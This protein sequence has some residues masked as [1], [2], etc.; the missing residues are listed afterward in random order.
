MKDENAFYITNEDN[1]KFVNKTKETAFWFIHR[2]K[3]RKFYIDDIFILDLL[4]IKEGCYL[5]LGEGLSDH[6][7]VWIRIQE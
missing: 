2:H 4:H 5:S 1:N 7:D 3:K 6:Q